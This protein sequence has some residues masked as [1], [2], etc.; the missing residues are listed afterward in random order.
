[1]LFFACWQDQLPGNQL[2]LLEVIG[3]EITQHTSRY[4]LAYCCYFVQMKQM[5]HNVSFRG[6]G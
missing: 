3:Q 4:K 2:K 6:S 1:M 5:R